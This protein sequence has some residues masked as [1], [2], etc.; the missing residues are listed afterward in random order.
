[1]RLSVASAAEDIESFDEDLTLSLSERETC[2]GSL[3]ASFTMV[4]AQM[5]TVVFSIMCVRPMHLH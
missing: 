4:A 3:V 5:A 2:H 1:M